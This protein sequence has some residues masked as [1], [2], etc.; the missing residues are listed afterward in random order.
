MW[1]VSL[2]VAG[3]LRSLFTSCSVPHRHHHHSEGVE[4]GLQTG[5]LCRRDSRLWI[6]LDLYSGACRWF[7]GLYILK[8][9]LTRVTSEKS[10]VLMSDSSENKAL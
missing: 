6:W 9:M 2:W 3:A 10:N 1:G 8:F 7:G 4:E 5:L